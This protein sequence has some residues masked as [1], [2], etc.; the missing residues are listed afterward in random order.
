VY[1]LL[2]IVRVSHSSF[3]SVQAWDEYTINY[4]DIDVEVVDIRAAA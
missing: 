4:D 3:S 2:L 1:I